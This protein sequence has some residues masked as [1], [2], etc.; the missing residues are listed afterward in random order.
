MYSHVLP[1]TNGKLPN[2]YHFDSKALVEDYVRELGIPATFFLPGFFMSNIPGGMLRPLPPNNSYTLA[3]PIPDTT[4]IPLFDARDTGKWIKAIILRRN[5]LLGK[6]VL[7]ATDYATPAEIMVEFQEVYP[8]A[9][10][11][12]GFFS[13]PHDMFLETMKSMGMPEFAAVEMLENMRLMNEGGYFGG[14]SLDE[15]HAILQDQLTT[16]KEHLAGAK[17]FADLK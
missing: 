8:G 5:E 6:R 7:A 17:A 3:L 1:V 15:S 12:A 9:G 14:E 2:V 10:K 4:P 16:W 13:M 11:T